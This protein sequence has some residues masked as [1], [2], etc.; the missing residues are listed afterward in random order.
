MVF[1][2][3][4]LNA[5]DTNFNKLCVEEKLQNNNII[6]NNHILLNVHNNGRNN[7]LSASRTSSIHSLN[8]EL[9]FDRNINNSNVCHDTEKSVNTKTSDNNSSSSLTTFKNNC[10][11]KNSKPNYSKKSKKKSKKRRK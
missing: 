1:F 10:R 5:N 4:Q 11:N 8:I 2:T 3:D 7:S 6:N 9:Y